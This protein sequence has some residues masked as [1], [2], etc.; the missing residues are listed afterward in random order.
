MER[1]LAFTLSFAAQSMDVF[2]WTV[3]TSSRSVGFRLQCSGRLRSVVV[4]EGQGGLRE[5]DVQDIA[6]DAGI[7]DREGRGL[8]AGGTLNSL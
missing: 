6:F 2:L 3:S 5:G 7:V 4:Y 8:L 1:S